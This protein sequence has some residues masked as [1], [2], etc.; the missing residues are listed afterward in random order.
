MLVHQHGN[1]GVD[2]CNTALTVLVREY[3][4]QLR[5]EYPKGFELL[6]WFLSYG[7][8]ANGLPS[9]AGSPIRHNQGQAQAEHLLSYTAKFT[10]NSCL[11]SVAAVPGCDWSLE[12]V[13]LDLGRGVHINELE[14]EGR[15]DNR[16]VGGRIN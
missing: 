14:C 5:H 10:N 3:V 9:N 7:A 6:T 15:T 2:T 13:I 11:N 4:Y 12:M 1:G 8:L 16:G